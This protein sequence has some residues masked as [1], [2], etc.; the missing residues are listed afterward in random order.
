MGKRGSEELVEELTQTMQS[1]EGVIS[2]SW[3]YIH[4]IE[5]SANQGKRD[6]DSVYNLHL[7]IQEALGLESHIIG[8]TA[9]YMKGIDHRDDYH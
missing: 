4:K 7:K 8:L 5:S 9:S 3:H 1:L 6:I 2:D